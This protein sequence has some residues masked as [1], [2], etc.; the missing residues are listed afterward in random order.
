MDKKSPAVVSKFENFLLDAR[1][2]LAFFR[3]V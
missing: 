1:T 2:G 3:W